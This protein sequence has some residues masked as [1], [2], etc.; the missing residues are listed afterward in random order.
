MNRFSIASRI[1]PAVSGGAAP[2]E[3]ATLE[4]LNF[5][6]DSADVANTQ[7]RIEQ[8]MKDVRP[9]TPKEQF[10]KVKDEVNKLKR[11]LPVLI[12]LAY[13]TNGHR[14]VEAT[15]NYEESI[16]SVLDIDDL[17]EPRKLWEETVKD[18]VE[19]LKIVMA[20]ITPG[21]HGLKV[22]FMRPANLSQELA[23]AWCAKQLGLEKY[24][25]SCKDPARAHFLVPRSYVLH[26]DTVSLFDPN[27]TNE[28]YNV[29]VN[30]ETLIEG[31]DKADEDPAPASIP[32]VVNV[33]SPQPASV[34][35]P[36]ASLQYLGVPY[37]EYE[38]TY[39]EVNHGG[40][41][42][43]VGDR[44]TLTFEIAC[45]LRHITG[46]NVQLLD[47]I[48]PNYEDFPQE[49]KI[50]AIT[51]AVNFKHGPM[52]KKMQLVIDAI[53]RKHAN[54]PEVVQALDELEEQDATYY[55]S[56]LEDCF[57]SQGKK[58]PMGIR[59]SFDG[60]NPS[61][62]MPM[63]IGIGPMIGALATGVTLLV[64]NEPSHLNLVAYIVGEAASGKSKLDALY[65]TWMSRLIQADNINIQIM[66]DWK[67]LPKK[68]RETTPRPDVQL[69]IQ[70]LRC[71]M[72]DVL[73]HFN[74]AQGKH[75]Y[76]YTAEADQLSQSNRS[77]AFANV[78][79]IIRQSYDGSE[80]RSS[81]AGENSVNANVPHVLWNM[82]LCTTPDG[83]HRAMP[84]V[85][86][87]ELTRIA[88]GITPD[89]TFAPLVL[90][91]PRK[92]K[93][94]LN[95]ERVA[96]L[97]ELMEGEID[98]PLLEAHSNKWLEQVRISTLMN[99]DNVRARQ[100]FRVAVT[101]MRYVCDMMLCAYAEWLLQN[102]DNRGKRKLP[103]W[104]NGAE[105][106][107]QYLQTHPMAV[108]KD[109]PKHF[110]TEE[111]MSA[112]DVVADYLLDNILYYFRNKLASAYSSE[113]Y[114]GGN[115][116]R[117]GA[118]DTIY[119]RLPEVFTLDQAHQVKGNTGDGNS[120]RQMV[121]NWKKQGLV[122]QIDSCTYKK[123]M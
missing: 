107:E 16:W 8:L 53:K 68:K 80:F 84:N 90:T 13:F 4:R 114:R 96:A 77:G 97:L 49:E 98:L 28:G 83:L 81:Y 54:R 100:R 58:F 23:Q 44:N 57:E 59:D 64:H 101:A 32:E 112:F 18:K 17:W 110:Q 102:L 56:A 10:R 50:Q 43:C 119:A 89:N 22:M 7:R 123:L 2:A 33:V 45:A 5:F 104:A 116:K 24:D 69:R 74:H 82:S 35:V 111:Y 108:A 42:P 19:T 105:T 20:Y 91:K 41:R 6:L 78:S 51:N 61:L 87:G 109:V 46:F 99:D 55:F 9:D 118:N 67:S 36:D 115:R 121:K 48:I 1:T 38:Q 94:K 73:D 95:I 103:K 117:P 37:S 15:R 26:L 12:P 106:A 47:R 62:R 88:I 120:T 60:I 93:S 31:I 72:A 92:E 66:A 27:L 25:T 34:A 63:L 85:T 39:W 70:P 29:S 52:P 86:D 71:S 21:T 65:Q 3:L 122:I 75:L 14:R 113:S 40:K 79:V 11:H 30:V 76:S